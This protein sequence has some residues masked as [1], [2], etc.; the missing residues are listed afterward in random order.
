MTFYDFMN[1]FMKSPAEVGFISG[2]CCDIKTYWLNMYLSQHP[3]IDY[4]YLLPKKRHTNFRR[5]MTLKD[6]CHN[7]FIR[8][9]VEKRPIDLLILEDFHRE[10]LEKEVLFM[11]WCDRAFHCSKIL[12]LSDSMVEYHFR[13]LE[14]YVRQPRI[15][16]HGYYT[17]DSIDVSIETDIEYI[18]YMENEHH[19]ICWEFDPTSFITSN[20]MCQMI[21]L[22]MEKINDIDLSDNRILVYVQSPEI[23]E[24]ILDYYTQQTN[25][26]V[27]TIHRQKSSSD[28]SRILKDQNIRLIISTNIKWNHENM[29]LNPFTVVIDFGM[30]YSMNEFGFL[31]L[32]YCKQRELIERAK[33]LGS[34]RLFR[35]M[36]KNFHDESLPYT[37]IPIFD[38]KRFLIQCAL[39]G[40]LSYF[41]TFLP[42]SGSW[43]GKRN[44]YRQIMV[45]LSTI[46]LNHIVK[47]DRTVN[48]KCEG[49]LDILN[50]LIPSTFRVES[51]YQVITLNHLHQMSSLP[52]NILILSTM[53]IAL[54]DTIQTSGRHRFF[55]LPRVTNR[56]QSQIFD[57]WIRVM[58]FCHGDCDGIDSYFYSNRQKFLWLIFELCL[59]NIMSSSEQ[60][61]LYNFQKNT[62]IEFVKRWKLIYSKISHYSL[63][64]IPLFLQHVKISLLSHVQSRIWSMDRGTYPHFLFP[65][66]KHY[67]KGIFYYLSP[68][69]KDCLLT[70]MWKV[71][72]GSTW[73]HNLQPYT[74][75]LFLM[76]DNPEP[77]IT[78]DLEQRLHLPFPS[79]IVQFLRD[80]K[81]GEGLEKLAQSFQ[82]IKTEKA[83]L[84]KKFQ[85]SVVHQI[86][87]EVAYRPNMS[88]YHEVMEDFHYWC[89]KL[90]EKNKS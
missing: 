88:K 18:D 42:S 33:I 6:F 71:S 19:Q 83:K 25:I 31:S 43:L 16:F 13:Y 45:D 82:N 68:I 85:Q 7:H 75:K 77:Y 55:N 34:G 66:H 41:L 4:M 5:S 10:S 37:E 23:C 90:L 81:S 29:S 44:N 86:Q 24:T 47:H 11:T 74:R 36:S 39:Y 76:N 79:S 65:K 30:M 56:Q 49:A 15:F 62:W 84:R 58:M 78:I 17:N 59:T 21:D 51:F 57:S 46:T 12:I 70:T 53:M 48:Q 28:I 63:P 9:D 26:L 27:N 60:F 22:V 20:D 14:K 69:L 67:V 54:I 61:D 72:D 52:D 73:T 80:F 2:E 32:D 40:K 35:I 38:W 3:H 89:G 64:N 1:S 8:D 87:Q 50:T